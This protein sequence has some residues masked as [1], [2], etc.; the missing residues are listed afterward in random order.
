MRF[1]GV[2]DLLVCLVVDYWVLELR[3]RDWHGVCCWAGVEA[4]LPVINKGRLRWKSDGLAQNVDILHL[5]LV[6]VP[7]LAAGIMEI[8]FSRARV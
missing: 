7:A 8:G 3:V 5:V 6:L 4:G 1:A 2:S